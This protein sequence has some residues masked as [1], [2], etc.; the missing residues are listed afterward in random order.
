MYYFINSCC[1]IA[2]ITEGQN[3]EPDPEP[4]K[5]NARTSKENGE[6]YV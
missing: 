1:N 6:S 4:S 5:S 3:D 2:M